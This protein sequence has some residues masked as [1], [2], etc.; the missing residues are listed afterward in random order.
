MDTAPA[1]ALHAQHAATV[2]S[3]CR[4]LHSAEQPPRLATLARRFGMSPFHFHRV[5]KALTGLTPRAYAAACRGARVREGLRAGRRVTDAIFDAGFNSNGRFYQHSSRLLGMT[6]TRARARGHGLSIR[7]AVGRCS[8]GAIL[9]A[10]TDQG[11]CAVSLGSDAGTL[12]RD[13][14]DRFANARLRSADAQF[15]RWMARVIALVEAPQVGHELP[16][17]VRGT[18]FQQRVWQALSEIPLGSTASYAQIAARIGRPRAVRAVAQACAANP[19]AVAIPCHRVLHSD[20]TLSG[21]RWGVQRKRALLKRE[22]AAA[23]AA[24]P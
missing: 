5:F 19:V 16:L 14:N 13:L 2:T 22:G 15:Q 17:D 1:T 6:P 10:A 4:L 3:A 7:F 21:Y 18:A 11:I 12:Q 9:V 8:L 23:M 20:G 24:K